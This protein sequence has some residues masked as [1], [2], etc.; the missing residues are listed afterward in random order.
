[1]IVCAGSKTCS[2]GVIE[3]KSDAIEMAE[4]LSSE[5]SLDNAMVRMNWS[6]CP[7]GCGV[8]GI[9]DIGFESCK[10]KDAEGN[11]VDGVHIYV[12]GK[13]TRLAKEAR[14]LHKSLPI[15]EAKYHVKYLLKNYANYK[16]KNE[17]YEAFDDRYLSE[18]Y[19]FQALRFYTKVNY[20]LNEK[21]DLDIEL[22]FDSEPTTFRKENLEIF[23]FGLKLFR[24]L[25][26]ENRYTGVEDF[27]PV[28]IRP[29]KLTK[30]EVSKLNPKVPYELSEAIYMMTHQDNKVRARVFSEIL[31]KLESIITSPEL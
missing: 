31:V 22:V 14:T 16:Y 24:L 5:I 21:L 2:F 13:I 3:N 26:G 9:A 6:G 30:D 1:M 18:N 4:F 29:R 12:G 15:T 8:H 19:S 20:V 23:H 28:L 27:E 7:K 25:T 17:S 11:I 10:A